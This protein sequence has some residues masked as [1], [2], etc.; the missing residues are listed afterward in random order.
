MR[1]PFRRP[2]VEGPSRDPDFGLSSHH[3]WQIHILVSLDNVGVSFRLQYLHMKTSVIL[4][5]ILAVLL[6]SRAEAWPTRLYSDAEVVEQAELIVIARIKEGSIKKIFHGGGS[7][8]E[9][10]A[11]L[12]VSRVIKGEFHEKE[13]PIMIH[14]GL[15][16][17]SARYQNDLAH[18]DATVRSPPEEPGESVRIYEDN[19]SEGFFRPSGDVHQEQIWLLRHRSSP[20]AKDYSDV[21]TTDLLGIWEPEDLQPPAKEQQLAKYLHTP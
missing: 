6:S 8:Y 1:P 16:P 3:D 7:S 11:I 4:V 21:S 2:E 20:R 10:R 13:L 17:V 5:G 12:I 14:Y 19:P 9:H 18:G 15:L